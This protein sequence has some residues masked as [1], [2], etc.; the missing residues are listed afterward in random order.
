MMGVICQWHKPR[1]PILGSGRC[2]RIYRELNMA[3]KKVEQDSKPPFNYLVLVDIVVLAC[4]LIIAGRPDGLA[5]T[6]T[7]MIVAVGAVLYR[8]SVG[9][10]SYVAR[11]S[12][13]AK[14]SV[15]NKGAASAQKVQAASVERA[16]HTR[17]NN[18]SWLRESDS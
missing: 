9:V 1:A 5:I 6:V 8:C 15:K 7:A 2:A 13:A 4:I 3:V 12:H 17:P 14:A 18:K 11:Q 10:K 16:P